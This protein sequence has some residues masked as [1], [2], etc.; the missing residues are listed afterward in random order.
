MSALEQ[1]LEDLETKVSFLELANQELSDLLYDQQ[2]QIDKHF[3]DLARQ[4]RRLYENQVS[5]DQVDERPPHY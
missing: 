3:H 2:Q 1:R 4:L 5:D